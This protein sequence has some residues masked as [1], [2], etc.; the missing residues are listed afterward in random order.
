MI[1]R[2]IRMEG[3]EKKARKQ[4][5]HSAP[6]IHIAAADGGCSGGV[7]SS[8]DAARRN[9][10]SIPS[11]FSRYMSVVRF[12]PSLSAA[13]FGPPI[14]QPVAC[15]VQS[16]SARSDSRI[17][18]CSGGSGFL[19]VCSIEGGGMGSADA[20]SGFKRTP[21][22]ARI[23]ARATRFCS[24]RMFPGQEYDEKAAIVSGGI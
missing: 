22:C 15:S 21:S 6:S 8:S 12:R 4:T 18:I 20:G 19:D 5:T 24:S 9:G 10:R 1:V 11:L 17:V 13:P 16:I 14:L 7:K 23:M 3:R 2:L